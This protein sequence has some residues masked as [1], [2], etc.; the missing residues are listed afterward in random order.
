[1]H[2]RAPDRSPVWGSCRWGAGQEVSASELP[3]IY[4]PAMGGCPAVGLVVQRT[5]RFARG[6]T[7]A[8]DPA[9][10]PIGLVEGPRLFDV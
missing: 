4:T 8:G 7:G 3:S 10:F 1:M 2:P 6:I 5:V 9:R